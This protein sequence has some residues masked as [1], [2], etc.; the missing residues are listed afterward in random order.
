MLQIHLYMYK[1]FWHVAKE[2]HAST[3]LLKKKDKVYHQKVTQS[4]LQKTLKPS[5]R[6]NYAIF[7]VDYPLQY[8]PAGQKY[9]KENKIEIHISQRSTNQNQ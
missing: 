5:N 6:V 3:L 8:L 1:M 7:F 4:K 9:R 2:L